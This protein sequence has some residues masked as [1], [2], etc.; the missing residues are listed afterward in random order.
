MDEVS[1]ALTDGLSQ[2]FIIDDFHVETGSDQ[3]VLRAI[4]IRAMMEALAR[5]F[6]VLFVNGELKDVPLWEAALG[7]K[8]IRGF[9]AASGARRLPVYPPPQPGHAPGPAKPLRRATHSAPRGRRR[10]SN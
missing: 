5:P 2:A 7:A 3:P 6:D 10:N 4:F 9:V 1:E 8:V